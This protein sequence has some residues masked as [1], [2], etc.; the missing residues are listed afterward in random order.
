M[1]QITNSVQCNGCS[2]CY[3]ICPQNCIDMQRDGEGFRYPLVDQ[4]R[5]IECGMCEAV[6]PLLHEQLIL[7]D[8]VAF[9]C[10][11]LDE[12][13]RLN[14]SSGGIF[15]LI[16]SEIIRQGGIVFGAVFDPAFSVIHESTESIDD[17]DRFRGSKYVQSQI[18][19]SFLE[20]KAV[21]DQ[22]RPVL[23]SGTP[24]QIGGLK[25]FLNGNDQ[26]LFCIDIICHGVPSPAVWERYV[27]YRQHQAKSTAQRIAFRRK[28]DGWKRYSV[29][30][31]FEKNTEYRATLDKDPYMRAF[32]K[33]ICLRPSCHD[34]GFKSLHRQSDITLADFWGIQN[35]LPHLDD[36]KGTSLIFVNSESGQTMFAQI[37]DQMNYQKVDINEAVKYNS[38]ATKSAKANPNRE[39]FMAALDSVPFDQMV[40]KYCI[41][42]MS[43]RMKRKIRLVIKR[44]IQL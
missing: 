19:D 5:C 16:A 27:T 4:S 38:A 23:F 44:L 25:S 17:L 26:N 22:G 8:P 42:K 33:D 6:C 13:I 35:I 1:I 39:K 32:L 3:S 43:V 37:K 15:S 21:L 18:G 7:N 36:D 9:A 29:S 11:N 10:Q 31:Q 2:A 12:T 28:N 30:F 40:G 24:C 14:S 20:V 34:C 41:D